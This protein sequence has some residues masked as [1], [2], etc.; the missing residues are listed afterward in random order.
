[1]GKKKVA[2]EKKLVAVRLPADLVR[3]AK[4]YAVDHDQEFQSVV[5]DALRLLLERRSRA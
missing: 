5:A 2:D 4:H 3:A 1:M